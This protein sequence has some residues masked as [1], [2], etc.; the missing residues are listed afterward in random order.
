M[1]PII[2]RFRL[3]INLSVHRFFRSNLVKADLVATTVV[4]INFVM[5]VRVA[6]PLTGIVCIGVVVGRLDVVVCAG[7][8][9]E[10]GVELF[11]AKVA[12]ATD[13]V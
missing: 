3:A 10:D 8:V 13:E 1:P 7:G 4:P 11:E 2:P 9:D 5:V 6:F 12:G